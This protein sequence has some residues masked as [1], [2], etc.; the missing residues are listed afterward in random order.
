MTCLI[1]NYEPDQIMNVKFPS[2]PAEEMFQGSIISNL[3][4]ILF[5]ACYFL[6]PSDTYDGN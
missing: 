3:L 2:V 6:V 1:I 4:M 5:L